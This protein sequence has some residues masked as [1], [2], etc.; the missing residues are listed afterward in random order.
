MTFNDLPEA[1]TNLLSKVDKLSMTVQSLR[2]DLKKAQSE[3][4]DLHVPMTVEQ[5]CAFL[6][7]KRGTMYAKLQ[8]GTIPATKKGKSYTLFQDE[9]LRWVETGR[10]TSVPMTDEEL[11]GTMRKHSSRKSVRI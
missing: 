3:K 11:L 10:R 5:A 8:D 2:E 9:L 6:N 7:M 1:I 4:S